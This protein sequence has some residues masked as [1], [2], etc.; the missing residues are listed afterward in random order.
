MQPHLSLA[1]EDYAGILDDVV[2]RHPWDE[3]LSA[4]ALDA[5]LLERFL[6]AGP[7]I[8]NDGYLVSHPMLLAALRDESSLL[9]RLIATGFVRIA[10]ARRSISASIAARA[11]SGVATHGRLVADPGWPALAALLDRI[12]RGAAA[13]GAIVPWPSRDLTPGFV[14]LVRHWASG[15][16]IESTSDERDRMG[17]RAVV[18][19]FLDRMAHLAMAPRTQWEALVIAARDAGQLSDGAGQD[20]LGI[21]NQ[22]Y[23]LNFAAALTL[24]AATPLTVTT[25]LDGS[26]VTLV[27]A[28]NATPAPVVRAPPRA[29][30]DVARAGEIVARFTADAALVGLRRDYLVAWRDAA[31]EARYFAALEA[32]GTAGAFSP[33]PPP[34]YDPA[35][36]RATLTRWIGPDEGADDGTGFVRLLVD[37]DLAVS[38]IGDG[39]SFAFPPE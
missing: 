33:R 9:N 38:L 31:I 10:A 26:L 13:G 15:P 11:A 35:P 3:P 21:A 36:A 19:Q 25:W 39:P 8:V 32:F 14:R 12:A 29:R 5:L 23:H 16:A 2:F 30:F 20:L 28:G 18:T 4:A 7:T 17:T 6:F 22:I 27:S 34:F 24:D 37:R 1:I